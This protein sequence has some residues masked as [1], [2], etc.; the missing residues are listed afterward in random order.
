MLWT[1]AL[2]ARILAGIRASS[3]GQGT[4][5]RSMICK[6]FLRDTRFTFGAKKRAKKGKPKIGQSVL[7]F[8]LIFG[9]GQAPVKPSRR[10]KSDSPRFTFGEK[11]AQL[12]PKLTLIFFQICSLFGSLATCPVAEIVLLSRTGEPTLA[13]PSFASSRLKASCAQVQRQL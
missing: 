8:W 1:G 10:A 6:L 4:M 9:K 3:L 12:F 5:E 2:L 13:D 11:V 7:R